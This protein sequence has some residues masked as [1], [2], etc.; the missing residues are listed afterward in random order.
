MGMQRQQRNHMHR[1]ALQN[2]RNM[3]NFS[4]SDHNISNETGQVDDTNKV[5]R[6]TERVTY[7]KTS[8]SF[9]AANADD[10]SRISEIPPV[11]AERIRAAGRGV[12]G[13]TQKN[14]GV[15]NS[16]E[17]ASPAWLLAKRIRTEQGIE[18]L[19]RYLDAM[20]PFLAPAERVWIA[21]SF[22][23]PYDPN[24]PKREAGSNATGQNS[25]SFGGMN[26]MMLMQ[27]L[28]QSGKGG[29]GGSINPAM[30]S[31][32]M[33]MMNNGKTKPPGQSSS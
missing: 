18:H 27:L 28:T 12:A 23:M 17:D 24:I 33:N 6:P 26:P 16:Y 8:E 9:K 1:N 2:G 5:N 30:L 7:A 20:E 4:S 15:Y 25:S 29:K 14:D 3:G 19:R 11:G 31:Q 10:T 22:G 21:R 13:K 32:L